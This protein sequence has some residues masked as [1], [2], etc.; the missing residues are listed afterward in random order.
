M[1]VSVVFLSLCCI[2]I[3]SSHVIMPRRQC[4]FMKKYFNE[5]NYIRKGR[6]DSEAEWT[7]CKSVSALVMVDFRHKT[8]YLI[9]KT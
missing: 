6:N 8:T 5:W 3:A 9:S 2:V 7:V 4:K 1:S